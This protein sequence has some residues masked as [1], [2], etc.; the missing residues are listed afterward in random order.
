[1]VTQR[2]GVKPEDTPTWPR[3][4]TSCEP[5][6]AIGDSQQILTSSSRSLYRRSLKLALDWAVMRHIW[7]GQ[8]LYIRSLF[9]ANKHI[10]QPRQQRVCLTP[11][12]HQSEYMSELMHCTSGNHRAD[13]RAIR[14]VQAP[15]S[16]QTAYSTRRQQVPAQPTSAYNRS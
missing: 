8:A 7:R 1:M 11:Q 13:R 9:E 14:G 15:R 5:A 10:T 3:N 12:L 16:I 4:H 2:L 6:P